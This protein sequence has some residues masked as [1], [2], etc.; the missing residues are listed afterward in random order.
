MIR[1][2]VTKTAI[3]H[4]ISSICMVMS[5]IHQY[6]HQHPR[7]KQESAL[8]GQYVCVRVEKWHTA[9]NEN[10]KQ[11]LVWT[12]VWKAHSC[13]RSMQTCIIGECKGKRRNTYLIHSVQ[14]YVQRFTKIPRARRQQR[15]P[16]RDAT[17]SNPAK[18]KHKFHPGWRVKRMIFLS[19]IRAS[20]GIKTYVSSIYLPDSTLVQISFPGIPFRPT[21]L[22]STAH[23]KNQFIEKPYLSMIL[24]FFIW[25][26]ILI[27][28]F[29][30][31]QC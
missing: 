29:Y 3:F 30:F 5:T 24:F 6:H 14:N 22:I 23:Q 9:K 20:C 19:L 25:Q 10:G 26:I 15:F 21:I 2:S 27:L 7:H 18:V 17:W 8:K 11:V 4:S 13:A 1:S 12:H 16:R 28:Y 31:F